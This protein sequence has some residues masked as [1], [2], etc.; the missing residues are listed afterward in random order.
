MRNKLKY[1][2]TYGAILLTAG[3]CAARA[4]NGI[5][6][7][8][9]KYY[10]LDFVVK[11]L[12][13]EKVTN[14]RHYLTTMAAG[15]HKAT[16]R[17]GNKVPLQAGGTTGMTY[18]DVG[19]NIDCHGLKEAD[20]SVTLLVVAEISNAT[21]AVQPPLIRQTKWDSDVIV[22]IGKPTVLFSSDDVASKGQ[23][24]LELTATPI[25]AR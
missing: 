11:E 2:V 6:A 17:N 8:Q 22:P 12:D 25:A 15:D 18:I 1:A 10:R 20:G 7:E 21:S 16:I 24:Q 23:M 14:S 19:V 5:P 9:G 3:M 4:Q 13:G